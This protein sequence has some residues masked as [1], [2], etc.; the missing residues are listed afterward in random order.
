MLQQQHH[1]QYYN[2]NYVESLHSVFIFTVGPQKTLILYVETYKN[3]SNR[4]YT[5]NI[6]R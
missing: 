1:L 3:N 4:L 6:A 5:H 2:Q